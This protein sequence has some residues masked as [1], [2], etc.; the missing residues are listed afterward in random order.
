VAIPVVEGNFTPYDVYCADDAFTA[1]TS[2]SI[3][4]VESLNGSAIGKTVPGPITLKLMREW[5]RLTHTTRAS[6]SRSSSLDAEELD[7]RKL[8]FSGCRL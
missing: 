7:H 8:A 3:V 2:P 6:G 5:R 4:P 1:S